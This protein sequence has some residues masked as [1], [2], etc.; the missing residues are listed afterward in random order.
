MSSLHYA[1]HFSVLTVFFSIPLYYICPLESN[2]C[3]SSCVAVK[4]VVTVLNGLLST[5]VV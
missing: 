2:C 1:V 3:H 4:E 5:G